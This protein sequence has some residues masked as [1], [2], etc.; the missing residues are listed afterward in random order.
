P[1]I[2][3]VQ[4]RC[5]LLS[6][7]PLNLD[8]KTPTRTLGR[9]QIS[10]S[11]EQCRHSR[12]TY[13]LLSV[14]LIRKHLPNNSSLCH[15]SL[16]K[17]TGNSRFLKRLIPLDNKRMPERRCLRPFQLISSHLVGFR[18]SVPSPHLICTLRYRSGHNPSLLFA[19]SIYKL[20]ARPLHDLEANRRHDDPPKK[21]MCRG[22]KFP[23]A[24]TSG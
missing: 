11:G 16:L 10:H 18:L 23:A 14:K 13:T 19:Q 7:T 22:S 12:S 1:T 21:A 5:L 24:H 3:D 9:Q 8:P 2:N 15:V 6:L 4:N 20:F 17:E